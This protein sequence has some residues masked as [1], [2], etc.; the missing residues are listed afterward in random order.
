[1]TRRLFRNAAVTLAAAA[2][3]FALWCGP[4]HAATAS[5]WHT[6]VSQATLRIGTERADNDL[7]TGR[8]GPSCI[9]VRGDSLTIGRNY[10]P[11]P[12]GVVAYPDIRVGG[13]FGSR[14]P[15]SGFP[16]PVTNLNGVTLKLTATG[17][18]T[19][20]WLT[21]VDSMIYAGTNTRNWWVSELVIGVRHQGWS[22]GAARVRKVKIG[23]RW[24]YVGHHFTGNGARSWPLTVFWRVRQA[25]HTQLRLGGFLH[26]MLA[27]GWVHAGE[28]D[29]NAKFGSECWSGCRGLTD[30][31]TEAS[32]P[33]TRYGPAGGTS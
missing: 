9:T 28:F 6:C 3:M 7:F 21:D 1:M 33:L 4:S 2:A 18:A 17:T 15:G 27:R 22:P 5:T 32:I 14:D 25:D 30:G 23:H 20:A 10:Q 11:Q 16:L 24:W 31:M 8:H 13:W 12:G 29:G 19:G 26:Y